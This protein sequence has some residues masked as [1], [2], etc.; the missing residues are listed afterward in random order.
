ML[1]AFKGRG[2]RLMRWLHGSILCKGRLCGA[3]AVRELLEL[4]VPGG[5]ARDWDICTSFLNWDV[6]LAFA[7]LLE[8]NRAAEIV[9]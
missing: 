6:L 2:C 7:Y 9:F 1:L 3:A 5:V 8:F 4:K